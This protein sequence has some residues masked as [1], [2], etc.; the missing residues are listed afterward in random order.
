QLFGGVEVLDEALSLIGDDAA[1]EA[2]SYLRG[3]YSELEAAGLSGRIMIDLG[4]VNQINYYTGVIF[5]G[6]ATG[7][8]SAVL[9]GGR[10]DQLA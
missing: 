6:Y 8:G 3:I 4:L 5:R 7:A 2:I 9:S 10:Y 1:V